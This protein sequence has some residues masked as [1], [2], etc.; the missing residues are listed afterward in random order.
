[1]HPS[2]D[3]LPTPLASLDELATSGD[4]SERPYKVFMGHNLGN[5]TFLLHVPMH[6]F[7]SISEVANDPSRDGDAVAQRKLDPSHAQKLATY[8]LKGLIYSA[9]R[10][11]EINQKERSPTL[12]RLLTDMGKQPYLSMQPLVVNIRNCKASGSDIRGMRVVSKDDETACFKVFLSQRH[13]LWVVDGQH[14]RKAMQLVFDFL[15][16]AVRNASYPKKGSLYS[17]GKEYPTS[18][19]VRAWQECFD[20]ARSFCNVTVEV[21]LGLDVD[22]E[23]QLF[24]DLNNLGKKVERSLALKFDNSNPVNLF[25]KEVLIGDLGMSIV[26]KDARDWSEDDGGLA[27]KDIVGVNALLILNKTN[28]GGASP[29]DVSDRKDIAINFWEAIQRIPSFGDDRAKI[30]TVAAQP[31]VLKALAKLTYDF[32]FNLRRG[33]E[34]DQHLNHLLKAIPEIDFSHE[35][36]MWRY[37]SLTEAQREE[38]G[39]SNLKDYLPPDNDGA[40]RDLGSFQ[41]GFMR[42]GAKHNDIFPIIGDMIRWKLNL[43]NR[44]S[45][46]V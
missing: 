20:A 22:Q 33:L 26:E 27:W 15:D 45:R 34:A 23:R 29:I 32:A 25:I 37:Y 43:P 28:I 31:V 7:Y 35:N 4:S 42:F 30:K 41:G 8:I 14:R 6:E 40:N 36:M 13:L 16:G 38:H 11:R 24:H 3:G 17:S 18:E 21:H 12:D 39:L 5:R 2:V 44:N 19:E 9:V 46:L 10:Y 1:M